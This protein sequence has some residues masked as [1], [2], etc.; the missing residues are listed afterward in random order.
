MFVT[1]FLSLGWP[2]DL[3]FANG[4][5][6]NVTPQRPEKYLHVLLRS[7]KKLLRTLLPSWEQFQNNLYTWR[8]DQVGSHSGQSLVWNTLSLTCQLTDTWTNP[9]RPELSSRVK[10]DCKT[11]E[12]WATVTCVSY[13]LWSKVQQNLDCLLQF[14]RLR[15]QGMAYLGP[16]LRVSQGLNSKLTD[17]ARW[18]ACHFLKTLWFG[19]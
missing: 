17:T 6:A 10:T 4:T 7:L 8:E 19:T 9:H 14:S 16:L 3:F 15:S 18:E 13:L 1:Q 5:L 11:A 12:L 2:C